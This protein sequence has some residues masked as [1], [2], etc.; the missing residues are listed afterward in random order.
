MPPSWQRPERGK[1][2]TYA[3]Y[4]IRKRVGGAATKL[5]RQRAR[6]RECR[7]RQLHDRGTWDADPLDSAPLLAAV[8]QLPPRQRQLVEVVYG[9][10][11]KGGM[12]VSRAGHVLGVCPQRSHQLHDKALGQLTATLQAS[13]ATGGA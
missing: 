4:C 12:P 6:R 5:M 9:L 11:G 7:L 2:S 1:F 3:V 8:A 10:D 13:E